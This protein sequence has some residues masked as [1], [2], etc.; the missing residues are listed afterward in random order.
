[1][2]NN[3]RK[4]EQQT[5]LR[6]MFALSSLLKAGRTRPNS[7]LFLCPKNKAETYPRIFAVIASLAALGDLTTGKVAPPVFFSPPLTSKTQVMSNSTDSAK[8]AAER[9]Q[10]AEEA[11]RRF[12]FFTEP[13]ETEKILTQ[14]FMD[15]MAS[16][17]EYSHQQRREIIHTYES[18][19]EI[20][21]F[22]DKYRNIEVEEVKP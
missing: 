12:V 4:P 2:L 22:S 16:D 7:G 20:V 15:C 6:S 1:M 3:I 8:R 9:T 14:M 18:F 17:R 5:G 10:L 21:A 13:K 11:I 19:S